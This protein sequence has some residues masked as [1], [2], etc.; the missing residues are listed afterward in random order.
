MLS[1]Q[2]GD[3]LQLIKLRLS[4][5]H[6]LP[7]PFH[8]PERVERLQEAADVLSAG[9]VEVLGDLLDGERAGA[10]LH[11]EADGLRALF[12]LGR[13]CHRL[14]SVSAAVAV[15][16]RFHKTDGV[17]MLPIKERQYATYDDHLL[18]FC[19]GDLSKRAIREMGE[20]INAEARELMGQTNRTALFTG[21]LHH[22]KIVD[23]KGTI[24]YQ[25]P[26]PVPADGYH[27][28]EAYVGARKLM[29]AVILT[30]ESGADQ[31]LHA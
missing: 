29:Q 14:Q 12:E 6:I 18:C 19:H 25:C 17:E 5:K 23:K 13:T 4:R 24:Y 8:Q 10:P 11:D 1:S 7:C 27:A 21:H 15:S 16:Q 31:I 2:Y 3:T 22:A 28:K 9:A 26:T 30:P 20:T